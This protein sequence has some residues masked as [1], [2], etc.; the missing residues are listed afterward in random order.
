[1]AAIHTATG[2]DLTRQLAQDAYDEII[3]WST[4]LSTTLGVDDDVAASIV[5]SVA[6]DVLDH[7]QIRFAATLATF[8]ISVDGGP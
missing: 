3:E 4:S 2:G 8:R 1:M 7:V 6:E 5:A